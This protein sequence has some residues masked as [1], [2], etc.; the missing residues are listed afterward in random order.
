FSHEVF[1]LITDPDLNAWYR[2]SD[3]EEI[4]DICAWQIA[5]PINLNGRSYAIQKEYSNL[6][7]GC[8][9]GSSTPFDY[10]LS[11]SGAVT[12][13]P[14]A[15]TGAAGGSVTATWSG[16]AGPTG[17]DWIGLYAQGAANTSYLA[18][19]YV[20]CSQAPG[21]AAAA[22]SCPFAIPGTLTAGTYELRLMASNG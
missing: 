17:T 10:S 2:T 20:S 8:V 19:A 22:G 5:N 4:G 18:W 12:V 14:G 15:S 21:A 9:A 13:T 7:H 6:D 1:E 16:I 11:V 3:G